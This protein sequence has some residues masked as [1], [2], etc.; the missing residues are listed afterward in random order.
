MNLYCVTFEHRDKDYDGKQSRFFRSK[1]E[2]LRAHRELKNET[3]IDEF[4]YPEHVFL[5][6]GVRKTKVP[7]HKEGLIDWLN[8][9]DA[10]HVPGEFVTDPFTLTAKGG[11]E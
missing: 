3:E 9:I 7:R 5:V 2:A 8:E 4:G 6:F 1:R 11:D 10:Q